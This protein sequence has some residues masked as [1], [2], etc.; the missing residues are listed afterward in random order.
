MPLYQDLIKEHF[1]RCLDLY[2][3]PRLLKKKVNVADMSKLIPELPSPSDLK[4]FPLQ[5]SIDYNFH[6]TSVRATDV[7]PNGLWL[8][9]GDEAGNLVIWSIK[10]SKIVKKYQL[11]NKVVDSIKWCPNEDYSMLVVANE[12]TVHLITP[13]L[14]TS[15]VNKATKA[16]IED[17]KK[18]YKIEEVAAEQKDKLCTWE[19]KDQMVTLTMKNVI[20]AVCWH[21][22]GD[23][24]S[25]LAHNIKATHQVLIHSVSKGTSQRPF[26][27]TKGII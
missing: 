23:Y 13:S 2:M 5:V 12:D 15:E 18:T 14:G 24:F 17:S 16:L 7:H 10:T 4:P 22:K 9:S 3:A 8:A 25:T 6:E 11:E 19:F 21:P 20:S 26:S 1:E 27:S